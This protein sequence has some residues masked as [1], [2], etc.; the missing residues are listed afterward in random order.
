MVRAKLL[1]NILIKDRIHR[2]YGILK[3][4]RLLSSAEFMQFLS[5]VRL[6]V[7]EGLIKADINELDNL[8]IK[9][10]PYSLMLFG[11]EA[12]EIQQRDIIRAN[13]VR[14]VFNK[15]NNI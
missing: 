15:I 14:E 6:G 13:I 2:A 3:E 4:V 8:F 5:D 12:L 11:G 7:A 10:Q 1:E 9:A